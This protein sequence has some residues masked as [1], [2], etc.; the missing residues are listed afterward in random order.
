MA[1]LP[2]LIV[3]ALSVELGSISLA[4]WMDAPVTS[5]ISRIFDPP[6]PIREPHCDAGTIIRKVIGGRV[7]VLGATKLVKSCDFVKTRVRELY[8]QF[9]TSSIWWSKESKPFFWSQTK[10]APAKNESCSQ[11]VASH[12]I[13]VDQIENSISQY[14]T[15]SYLKLFNIIKAVLLNR[16]QLVTRLFIFN[17]EDA[18][19]IYTSL[20]VKKSEYRIRKGENRLHFRGFNLA[21]CSQEQ[22]LS[23][24]DHYFPLYFMAT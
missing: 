14:L 3:T 9:S 23:S 4:T 2:P 15:K 20:V 18:S 6:F 12:T 7:D 22:H 17:E 8:R 13:A 19:T 21:D 16:K 5:R 1:S 11:H 10:P 24:F